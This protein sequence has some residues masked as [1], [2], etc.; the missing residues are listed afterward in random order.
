MAQEPKPF[1]WQQPGILTGNFSSG[2]QKS[3]NDRAGDP[4]GAPGGG[5]A[6]PIPTPAVPPHPSTAPAQ[7]S[8][9]AGE[10][11]PQLGVSLA[12]ALESESYHPVI[13]F[14][15]SFSGKTS[16]LLSLFSSLKVNPSLD[17]GVTL[18]EPILGPNHPEGLVLHKEARRLFDNGTQA[19]IRGQPTQKT[20]FNHPFFVPVQLRAGDKPRRNF[21]FLES[22]GEWYQPRPL[23]APED[24]YPELKQSI[25]SFITSFSGAITFIY[26]LPYTQRHLDAPGSEDMAEIS[27]AQQAVVG[28]LDA[29]DRIRLAGRGADKHLMLVTKWDAHSRKS[30]DQAQDIVEDRGELGAFVNGR[31]PE[32][33]KRLQDLAVRPDQRHLNAYS[34]GI[35]GQSGR[36]TAPDPETQQALQGYPVRLWNLLY[37]NALAAAG[38]HPEP[39]FAPPPQPPAAVRMFHRVLD[40]VSGR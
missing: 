37:N 22:K 39:L 8:P 18:C 10:F 3:A 7:P 26:L 6:A 30:V 21:A 31:Y 2:D 24:L 19:F 16:L 29:Y 23:D 14:G 20:A 34:A 11:S 38:E 4:P 12:Q 1:D 33:I 35:I 36:L 9:E 5:S 25:E 40:F 17:A 28:V 15:T 27:S 13:L 32:A